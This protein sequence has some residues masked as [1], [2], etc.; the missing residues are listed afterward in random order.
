L[1]GDDR[2]WRGGE[3][4]RGRGNKGVTGSAFGSW[5]PVLV[6]GTIGL[7]YGPVGEASIGDFASVCPSDV[8]SDNFTMVLGSWRYIGS[9][10]H[11]GVVPSG[12]GIA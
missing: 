4:S 12:M 10:S 7:G 3:T 2:W 9:F 11:C 1:D 5:V 6:P 8:L